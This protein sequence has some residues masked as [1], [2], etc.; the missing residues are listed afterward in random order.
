MVELS[1]VVSLYNEEENIKPLISALSES[2]E[3]LS[4]E[5]LLVDDG[6]SDKTVE[7]KN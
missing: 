2:L 6:S 5:V 1:V 3:G 7:E 4:Y